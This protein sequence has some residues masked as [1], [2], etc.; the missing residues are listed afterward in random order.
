[1]TMSLLCRV[2][3]DREHAPCGG[4]TDDGTDRLCTCSCH[5][6]SVT[7]VLPCGCRLSSVNDAFVFEA[8]SPTCEWVA[9]VLAQSAAQ[10][11]PAHI[12]AKREGR[13]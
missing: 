6:A 4:T 13:P 3:Q 1:M 11:K 5:G 8:C 7:E 12:A 2:Q 9:Y 10:G